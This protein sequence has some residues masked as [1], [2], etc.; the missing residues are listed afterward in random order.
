M[1]QQR[2]QQTFPVVQNILEFLVGN[3]SSFKAFNSNKIRGNR[4][5]YNLTQPKD[6][7]NSRVEEIEDDLSSSN[8][9][10]NNPS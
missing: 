5:L 9:N 4:V 1:Y 6:T 7:G 2:F 3:D 8:A 10:T